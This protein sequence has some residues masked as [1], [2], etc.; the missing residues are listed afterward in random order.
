MRRLLLTETVTDGST[1]EAR[2]EFEYDVY[3]SDGSHAPLIT[4]VG[5]TMYNSNR[6]SLFNPQFEPR[7]NVTK[8][9]RWIAGTTYA[10]TYSQYDNGGNVLR[11]KDPLGRFTQ[12]SYSDNYGDGTNP[13][14]GAAGPNGSTFA[15]PT[16][17]T[18]ALSQVTK[19][20]YNYTRGAPTGMKDPNL[21]ITRAEYNDPYDRATRVTAGYGLSESETSITEMSYPTTD[22][23]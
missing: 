7:G 14:A 16:T 3:T 22:R 9:R 18:N 2:T 11:V 12:I 19:N 17:V 10:E 23:N 5:M 20:Q 13:D 1:Q 21:V 4:N 8:V 6:F 15:F